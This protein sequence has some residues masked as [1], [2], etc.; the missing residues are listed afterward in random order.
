MQVDPRRVAGMARGHHA[1]DHHHVVADAGLLVEADD[2][3]EQFVEL[4]IAEHALDLGQAQGHR[5]LDA[6]GAGHQ[7]GR[8]LGAG[9]TRV[10]L[11]DRLEEADLQACALQGAHQAEADGG[12]ADTEVGRRNEK[13]LHACFSK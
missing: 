5:G 13:C 3:F 4:A 12:Q 11:G 10:G 9:V 7:F 8:A 6:M 1:F 2:R